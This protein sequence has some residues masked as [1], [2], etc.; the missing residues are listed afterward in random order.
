MADDKG[1]KI[2]FNDGTSMDITNGRNAPV[3]G[4]KEFEDEYYWAITTN[5][6]TDFVLDKDNNKLVVS[7]KDG[8]TPAMEIDAEGYWTVNGVRIKDAE[9]KPVKA[10]GDSF[11]KNVE[12]IGRA[13]CRERV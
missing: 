9:D 8:K 3:M 10:Q 1:Y 4:I 11:F 6:V 2:T 12:E 7:G 13:S 5:G